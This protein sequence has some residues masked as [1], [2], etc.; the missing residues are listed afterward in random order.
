VTARLALENLTDAE[1][2]YELG[3]VRTREYKAGR[4]IK[5]DLGYTF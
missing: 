4:Q 5:L 3:D 2:R 1:Y